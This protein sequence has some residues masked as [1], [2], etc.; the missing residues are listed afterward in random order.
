M[1]EMKEWNFI[2]IHGLVLIYISRNSQCTMRE[3]AAAINVTERTIK[4]VLEDLYTAGYITWK[5]TGK[6]NIYE[7]NSAK[8]L[9]H[10]LTRDVMVGDLLDLLSHKKIRPIGKGKHRGDY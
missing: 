7:M 2:T 5:R 4:R 3:M 9:K 8:G 6:G 1:K 10:E